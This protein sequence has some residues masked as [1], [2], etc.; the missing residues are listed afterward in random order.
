MEHTEIVFSKADAPAQEPVSEY[1][2]GDFLRRF[3][4]ALA[5]CLGLAVLAN[6]VVMMVGP[7]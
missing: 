2:L 3:G 4:A 6:A 5:V 7:G 1:T